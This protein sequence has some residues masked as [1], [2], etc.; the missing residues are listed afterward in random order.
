[1]SPIY[2]SKPATIT[3]LQNNTIK[4]L[5]NGCKI[6]VFIKKC[7]ALFTNGNLKVFLY[8]ML[9]TLEKRYFI[10]LHNIPY[11]CFPD[12]TD[13]ILYTHLVK[14]TIKI[15][16][17]KSC[18]YFAVCL[19]IDA[20]SLS[21]N[22]NLERFFKPIP[23]SPDEVVIEV[24]K[25]CNLECR[26]CLAGDIKN[27]CSVSMER[28]IKIINE[29]CDL[30]IR[31]L[32]VTGG[33]PLLRD[34][35][36]ELLRY[37]KRKNLYILL[38]T[39][40]TLLDSQT[41]RRIEHLVDNILI[42]IQGYDRLS[43]ERFTGRG[44]LFDAKMKNIARVFSSAIPV[45][46][47]GTVITTNTIKE[48]SHYR[49]LIEKFPVDTWEL[50]RPMISS[51]TAKRLTKFQLTA[52]HL[53][54]LQK[55]VFECKLKGFNAVIANAIPFCL[56]RDQSKYIS[57]LGARFDDGHSRL[58]YDAR[59][60]FKPSYYINKN[61]GYNIVTAWKHPFSRKLR[62]SEWIPSKCLSCKD[63]PGCK[64]GSRF[65]AKESSGSYFSADPLMSKHA[66]S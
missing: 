48:F 30:G 5:K 31:N 40:A 53:K 46:R 26:I 2:T 22:H 34:D 17:C 61:V 7:E 38:N 65:W 63:L 45:K 15:N 52:S 9:N 18:K 47:V 54:L 23:D 11:C 29:A 66:N 60:F 6:D 1:M 59:G 10:T 50:Y 24:T 64:A 32:R 13:H 55:K 25:S 42:S 8:N 44:D 43:E 41:L 35:L 14:R 4:I 36:A 16:T 21:N 28:A 37:A 19:G 51:I 49:A 58:I 39:N 57:L 3:L 12:A 62:S 33:E 56:F 27:R 20:S